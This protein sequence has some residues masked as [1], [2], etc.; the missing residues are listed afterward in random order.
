[1]ACCQAHAEQHKRPYERGWPEVCGHR[2]RHEHHPRP[3]NNSFPARPA[4]SGSSE[5][6]RGGP[7]RYL[8]DDVACRRRSGGDA[9]GCHPKSRRRCL[10]IL[11]SRVKPGLVAPLQTRP[12]PPCPGHSPT[13]LSQRGRPTRHFAPHPSL[14]WG[15]S[16]GEGF[17]RSRL[18]IDSDEPGELVSERRL[19]PQTE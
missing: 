15:A 12:L 16:L 19:K 10:G 2:E 13:P 14:G 9:I 4:V 7:W 1:M 3:H 6:S 17:N 18:R 11:R 5:S 8:V